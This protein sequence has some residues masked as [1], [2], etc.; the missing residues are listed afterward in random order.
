MARE[1]RGHLLLEI[2]ADVARIH[3]VPRLHQNAAARL[4][5]S[6][7]PAAALAVDQF[8][9]FFAQHPIAKQICQTGDRLFDRAD[10][11]HNLRPFLQQLPQ[12]PVCLADDFLHV[13]NVVSLDRSN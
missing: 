7:L 5:K 3:G 13:A 4:G 11:F 1:Q 12:F 8:H 6:R 9:Q 2:V 10:A